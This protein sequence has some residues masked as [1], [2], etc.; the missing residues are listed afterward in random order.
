LADLPELLKS[1]AELAGSLGVGGYSNALR[2]NDY[3]RNFARDVV[4]R[5][6]PNS[7]L[8][9]K[10]RNTRVRQPSIGSSRH[11]ITRLQGMV[12]LQP[13]RHA[14]AAKALEWTMAAKKV[15][16]IGIDAGHAANNERRD[17]RNR[18]SMKALVAGRPGTRSADL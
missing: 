15:I 5:P 16:H 10:P 14:A 9:T 4:F 2:N 1:M 6:S 18:Y 7:G 11:Q 13:D 12:T 8:V 3:R 17:A